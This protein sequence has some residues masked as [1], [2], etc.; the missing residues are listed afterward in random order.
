L[1]LSLIVW[2]LGEMTGYGAGMGKAEHRTLNYD[3]RRE[4]HL[5]R[6]DR[7]LHFNY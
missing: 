7:E 1:L 6:T 5:S 2:S 4:S 3:A